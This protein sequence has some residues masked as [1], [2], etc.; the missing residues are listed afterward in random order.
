MEIE[1]SMDMMETF[2]IARKRQAVLENFSAEQQMKKRP[3]LDDSSC[4]FVNVSGLEKEHGLFQN[5]NSLDRILP[6]SQLLKESCST[7]SNDIILDVNCNIVR[8]DDN[9]E[10][11]DVSYDS[12]N[13]S[14]SRVHPNQPT[15]DNSV[16]SSSPFC[17]RCLRGEPGH[18]SHLSS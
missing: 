14:Q 6:Y 16:M 8:Q 10:E 3:C 2:N 11:M 4:H 15:S 17:Y 9:A 7:L 1:V 13:N 18:I 12:R 5:P